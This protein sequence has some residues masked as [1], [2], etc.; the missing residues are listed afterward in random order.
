M[1]IVYRLKLN[2][3]GN[4]LKRIFSIF[5]LV[6]FICVAVRAQNISSVFSNIEPINKENISRLEKLAEF[7]RGTITAVDWLPDGTQ[8]A[9]GGSAGVWIYQADDLSLAPKMPEQHLGYVNDLL[10]GNNGN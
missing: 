8:V 7:G 2:I 5:S 10:Y 1:I 9:V 3:S 4:L 6:L